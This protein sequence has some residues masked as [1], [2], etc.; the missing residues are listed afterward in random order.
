MPQTD[1]F[2]VDDAI[3]VVLNLS[4]GRNTIGDLVSTD[5]N[6]GKKNFWLC[7][8]PEA[9]DQN[10]KGVTAK[11]VGI[12]P[13]P[14]TDEILSAKA[15]A[16]KI[17]P[18]GAELPRNKTELS[19]GVISLM[20][21]RRTL[22]AVEVPFTYFIYGKADR[23]LKAGEVVISCQNWDQSATGKYLKDAAAKADNDEIAGRKAIITK[24]IKGLT[25]KR[26][27]PALEKAIRA[28]DSAPMLNIVFLT[29]GYDFIR[30]DL[31]I[32]QRKVIKTVYVYKWA[33]T[34]RC[35]AHWKYYGYESLG[36]GAF[37]TDLGNWRVMT[38]DGWHVAEL[39]VPG[40]NGF[41]SGENWE[42][43]CAA[44]VR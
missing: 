5:P 40:T 23:P 16:Y 39:N 35:F 8:S 25:S 33:Q 2:T 15:V 31:G 19:D 13:E 11:C 18:S 30:N 9:G 3:Y 1:S 6:T 34:G 38:D 29:P 20:A 26:T 17:L 42:V 43:D 41:P 37:D 32:V 27:D 12:L 44:F 24:W 10:Y 28:S 22:G 36:G 4:K 21:A 14:L 7:F